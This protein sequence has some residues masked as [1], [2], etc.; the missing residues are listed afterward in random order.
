M[1]T[2]RKNLAGIFQD[3]TFEAVAMRSPPQAAQHSP[4]QRP[5]N[6]TYVK[7]SVGQVLEYRDNKDNISTVQVLSAGLDSNHVPFYVIQMNDG[8]KST[9]QNN[10]LSFPNIEL[11]TIAI[12]L[13]LLGGLDK[14]H[15][16]KVEGRIK[17]I[18]ERGEPPRA[19]T[20]TNSF[21]SDTN[22]RIN[23][24]DKEKLARNKYPQ[25]KKYKVPIEE[26]PVVQGILKD[27]LALAKDH[28]DSGLLT[29]AV[30]D[31]SS[32]T[33]IS[34][35]APR[36]YEVFRKKGQQIVENLANLLTPSD[37]QQESEEA[38]QERGYWIIRVLSNIFPIQFKRVAKERFKLIE[39]KPLSFGVTV[40]IFLGLGLSQRKA[41]RLRS[42]LN[43]FLGFQ[44]FAS[45][46]E[47]RAGVNDMDIDLPDHGSWKN[48]KGEIMHYSQASLEKRILSEL[49]AY[50][51]EN[52]SNGDGINCLDIILGGDHGQGSFVNLVK[53]IPKTQD[54]PYGTCVPN[55]IRTFQLS[56]ID[57][58]TDS[59]E[60][61]VN[62][63]AEDLNTMFQDLKVK[64]KLL[65]YKNDDSSMEF[66]FTR[67][68]DD[69]TLRE[70][71]FHIYIVGDFKFYCT[72]Q[73][74]VN[75]AGNWCTWCLRGP[76]EK[77]FWLKCGFAC[78]H[79]INEKLKSFLEGKL[80]GR[81]RTPR[82]V[83]GV[84][85]ENLLS[86]IEPDHYIFPTLHALTLG[87]GPDL[88]E[89]I[90]KVIIENFVEEL[91]DAIVQIQADLIIEINRDVSDRQKVARLKSEYKK[92]I[93]ALQPNEMPVKQKMEKV[94]KQHYIYREAFHGGK[95]NGGQVSR[96]MRGAKEIFGAF[97]VIILNT[98]GRRGLA[99]DDDAVKEL[100]KALIDIF[101]L[102]DYLTSLAMKPCGTMTD[103][104]LDTCSKLIQCIV[105]AWNELGMS[106]AIIKL[107]T[108]ANHLMYWLMRFR[109]L[110]HHNEQ[111][112]ERHHQLRKLHDAQLA[113]KR[114][115]SVKQ[116]HFATYEGLHNEPSVAEAYACYEDTRTK[117][118]STKNKD[119]DIAHQQFREEVFNRAWSNFNSRVEQVPAQ[120]R[121]LTQRV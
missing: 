115:Y 1:K 101:I 5:A 78:E 96:L 66:T 45:A 20:T 51:V 29:I 12:I 56:H 58:K 15:V 16:R 91:P 111:D 30:T 100:M 34:I 82:T 33:V 88:D 119:S 110:A 99:K 121:I 50:L 48:E 80:S 35:P 3:D 94:Y 19:D 37:K 6:E 13:A 87:P 77:D 90:F 47:V 81:R 46:R 24:T 104:D 18:I 7:Y 70:V 120:W 22:N 44:I 42:W 86:S 109:G 95:L 26:K 49:N 60:I 117:I 64:E 84:V 41:N 93:A 97:E 107:H 85:A 67:R 21:F 2:P 72:M 61:L 36:T 98:Q 62:T 17:G 57:S 28:P 11:E 25:L 105:R 38:E 9:E 73:G 114:L 39:T 113:C 71:P 31:R 63:I 27:I 4:L 69:P 102:L 40:A 65:L 106:Q 75:M 55:G 76:Y 59:Y 43:T 74:K 92:Q 14:E 8:R 10:R 23:L 83:R 89:F 52:T 112:V 68:Q 53:L 118:H 54:S 32:N 116:E 108:I 79:W 103:Q